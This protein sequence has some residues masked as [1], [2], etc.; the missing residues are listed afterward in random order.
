MNAKKFTIGKIIMLSLCPSFLIFGYSCIDKKYDLT[1]DIST[2]V[3]IGGELGFPLGETET[4]LLSDLLKPED[5]EDLTTDDDQY[6]IHKKENV[7]A[8]IPTFD[9]VS[10]NAINTSTDFNISFENLTIDPI[11]IDENQ[12]DMLLKK[13]II[14][15]PEI[16]QSFTGNVSMKISENTP[17][18]VPNNGEVSIMDKEFRL[19]DHQTSFIV[20]KGSCPVEV[21]HISNIKFKGTTAQLKM[22]MDQLKNTLNLSE[23]T[24]TLKNFTIIFPNTF[25][26]S[27]PTKGSL[28]NSHTLRLDNVN[29]TLTDNI[30]NFNLV[31][32]NKEIDA[33]QGEFSGFEESID[34]SQS[35]Y[36]SIKGITKGVNL[37]SIDV[38]MPISISSSN[39][40]IDDMDLTV[41]DLKIDV[42][43]TNFSTDIKVTN[44]NKDVK[45]INKVYFDD[46]SILTLKSE[47]ITLAGLNLSGGEITINLNDP[48]TPFEFDKTGNT[49]NGDNLVITIDEL[50][51]GFTKQVKLKSIDLSQKALKTETDGTK[52]LSFEPQFKVNTFTTY[53]KGNTTFKKIESFNNNSKIDFKLQESILNIADADVETESFTADLGNNT[54]KIEVDETDV[55]KELKALKWVK[56]KGNTAVNLQANINITDGAGDLQFDELIIDFPQYIIFDENSGVINYTNPETGEKSQR[57]ILK[58]QKFIKGSSTERT[59]KYNNQLHITK[60]DFTD[61]EFQNI[62]TE[63]HKLILPEKNA[64]ITGRA[65]VSSGNV[66]L[67]DLQNLNVKTSVNVEQ[68]N[69][70]LAAGEV[71]EDVISDNP[72]TSINLG[73]LSD[74]LK[75]GSALYLPNANFQLT[76]TNPI[77]VPINVDLIFTPYKN[78]NPLASGGLR[79]DKTMTIAAYDDLNPSEEETAKTSKFILATPEYIAKGIPEGFE[80]IPFSQLQSVIKDVPDSIVIDAIP[81]P[82]AV[83]GEN[84]HT[85]DLSKGGSQVLIDCNADVPFVLGKDVNIVYKDTI[86]N[87]QD[88]TDD[89]FEKATASEISIKATVYNG[90][91]LEL[92][93]KVIPLSTGCVST[94]DSNDL[95]FTFDNGKEEGYVAAGTYNS[96]TG[97]T[98]TSETT[99]LIK[100]REREGSG[101]L[102]RLDGLELLITG[103]LGANEGTIGGVPLKPSQ[104]IKAKVALK[105]K[106]IQADIDNF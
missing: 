66:S 59:W 46:N 44:I 18:N 106:G 33:A 11:K 28:I 56:L 71:N 9:P 40:N 24:V 68:M 51:T 15:K 73:D 105:V 97:S 52:S 41:S 99:L 17:I 89:I 55:P 74:Y 60:L 62:L 70:Q 2:I 48:N 77:G 13:N 78:G 67:D 6:G 21:T 92:A 3:G 16:T 80:A 30:V 84:W 49:W 1:K 96:E 102:R 90:L 14:D 39:I 72:H 61:S 12:P 69:I 64:V 93:L 45:K 38:S 91:P 23:A 101:A 31:S 42:E 98:N 75:E 36:I 86:D 81:T 29:L 65:S 79:P 35:G 63:D 22:D 5:I 26:I 87:I 83:E 76:A 27:N 82:K 50:K 88:D 47:P 25:E 37:S 32:Y 103:G 57:L 95:S 53:A 8:D 7:K 20:A 10:I 34:Y 43:Q 104:S 58:N 94:I 85:V 100:V 54:A 19:D 4:K